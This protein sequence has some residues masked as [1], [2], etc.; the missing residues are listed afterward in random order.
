[1]GLVGGPDRSLS[2]AGASGWTEHDRQRRSRFLIRFRRESQ[3]GSWRFPSPAASAALVSPEGWVTIS[4]WT[5]RQSGK[6]LPVEGCWRLRWPRCRYPRRVHEN[7]S[8]LNQYLLNPTATNW[9]GSLTVR[10]L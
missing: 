2:M 9:T 10:R 6:T 1:V 8:T 5:G 7:R 3:L 4:S